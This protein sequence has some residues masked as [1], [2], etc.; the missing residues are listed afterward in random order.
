M[1]TITR[2][3]KDEPEAGEVYYRK[4]RGGTNIGRAVHS[5]LQSID[6]ATGTGLEDYARAQAQAEGI[7]DRWQDVA[8]LTRNALNTPVVRRAIASG[9]YHREV[10]ASVTLEGIQLEGFIDLMFE[11]HGSIVIADYKT[12]AVKSEIEPEMMQ[13]YSLQA[14]AYALAVSS[15]TGKPVREV[16][17]VFAAASTEKSLK[18]LEP[19][20]ERVRQ[21]AEEAA[22]VF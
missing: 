12:D 9:R 11:E 8:R 17:L 20:F 19:L 2:Q 18:N 4:G 21:L 1:T 3:E 14:A 15:I 10:F 5:T 16:V 13:K 7:P 6:L 22:G